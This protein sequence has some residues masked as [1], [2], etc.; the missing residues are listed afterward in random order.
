MG[1]KEKEGTH[2]RLNSRKGHQEDETRGIVLEDEGPEDKCPRIPSWDVN[3]SLDNKDK[4]D[5]LGCEE[6][7][8]VKRKG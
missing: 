3:W 8:K 4:E 1:S 2:G 5:L 6:D 7:Q